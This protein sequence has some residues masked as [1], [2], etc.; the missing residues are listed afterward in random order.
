MLFM[1]ALLVVAGCSDD[2]GPTGTT[3]VPNNTTTS[4]WNTDGYWVST[5]DASDYD[6]YMGF[7]FATQDTTLSGVG[8]AL[9]TGWDI[10]FRREAVKL[11][12]GSSTANDGDCEGTTLGVVDFDAVTIADTAGLEWSEDAIDF[13]I[14]DWYDYN[15][16]TH[17]LTAN[18]NVYSMVDAEGDNYVK[19]QIDSMVGAGMPPDMGT[20]YLTYFYQATASS[21]DLS[22]AT[23]STSI[24]VGTGTAYFDF[25]SG[26]VVTPAD[27]SNSTAW[28]L[29]F[30]S[31]NVMQNS[32]PNGSGQCAAFPAYTELATAHDIAAFTSQPSGAPMFGDIP[33]SVLTEWYTYTGPPSHQL[34]SNNDVYLIRTGGLVYKLKIESYYGN[35]GG[36]PTSGWYTFHWAEL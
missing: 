35:V 16:Q 7:S 25:S 8:K 2:D 24:A 31:Y 22:G 11:N 10:A 36:V 28:D 33:Q 14:D 19:F 29:G 30:S 12:G 5:V 26:A 3:P 23:V 18:R 15:P 27:P 21:N 13:F 17:Q 20:I 4:E 34:L 32:G 1:M 9:A 6:S